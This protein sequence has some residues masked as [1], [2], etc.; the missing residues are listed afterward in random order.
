MVVD[1]RAIAQVVFGQ[2]LSGLLKHTAFDTQHHGRVIDG[3]GIHGHG[4][5]DVA[6]PVGSISHRNDIRLTWEDRLLRPRR[7]GATTA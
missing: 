2:G 1:R 6:W 7:D 3:I 4:L 5:V